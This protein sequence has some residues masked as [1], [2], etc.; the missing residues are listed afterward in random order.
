MVLILKTGYLD[1]ELDNLIYP[2]ILQEDRDFERASIVSLVGEFAVVFV[3]D[4][5]GS[6]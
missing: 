3:P 1:S 2:L 6:M 5:R 4:Q